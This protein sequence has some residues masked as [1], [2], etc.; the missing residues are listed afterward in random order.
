M[1]E[2]YSR[3]MNQNRRET[4]RERSTMDQ[5]PPILLNCCIIGLY[6]PSFTSHMAASSATTDQLIDQQCQT[7][8]ILWKGPNNTILPVKGMCTRAK[9]KVSAAINMQ[10]HSLG[11]D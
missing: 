11:S 8:C 6:L 5:P 9:A 1:K 4:D 10:A 3:E 7:S 2:S